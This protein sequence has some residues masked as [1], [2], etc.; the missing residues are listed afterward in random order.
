M[1]RYF[2]D[3]DLSLA[4]F[5]SQFPEL[6]EYIINQLLN[7]SN[8]NVIYASFTIMKNMKLTKQYTR[9]GDLVKIL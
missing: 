9:S 2:I 7:G 1:E 5:E 6:H 3:S 4:S 8:P